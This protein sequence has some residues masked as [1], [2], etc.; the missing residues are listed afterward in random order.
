MRFM[1]MVKSE[2]TSPPSPALMEEMGKLMAREMSAGRLVDAGGLLPKPMGFEVRLRDGKVTLIDGPFTEAR[3]VVGGYA[4]FDF[5][6]REE[7]EAS[8]LE[9]MEMHRQFA[10]GWEGV[11]EA[12]PMETGEA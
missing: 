6:N 3:E 4:I 10:E 12:R 1:M 9:F 2:N 7:A 8:A 11:C 5:A